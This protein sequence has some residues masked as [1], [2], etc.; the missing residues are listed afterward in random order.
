MKSGFVP[1]LVIAGVLIVGAVLTPRLLR[2]QEDRNALAAQ[3]LAE[4]A[5]R[6]LAGY[7]P[8]L[9][10]LALRADLASLKDADFDK[11]TEP[12]ANYLVDLAK[13]ARNAAQ[14]AD[15]AAHKA[16]LPGKG[17]VLPNGLRGAV[18][19]VDKLVRENDA[20]LKQASTDAQTALSSGRSVLGVAQVA[21]MTRLVEAH[22]RWA[23]ALRLRSELETLQ[24][25]A[26][27]LAG[28]WSLNRAEVDHYHGLDPSKIKADLTADLKE[29]QQMAA[30]AV[31]EVEDLKKQVSERSAALDQTRADLKKARAEQLA[32]EEAGFTLGDDQSLATYRQKYE[33]AA[34]AVGKLQ[35]HE[36]LLAGGGNEGGRFVDDNLLDGALEGGTTTEGL[37]QLEGR[38]AEAQVR[39]ERLS[40]G[41]KTI[42]QRISELDM[43]G[44]ESQESEQRYAAAG[45]Y[46]QTEFKAV[47]QSME[48]VA[49][50]AFELEDQ[51][52][53]AA[54]AA[55]DAFRSAKSAADAWTNQ[56]RQLAGELDPTGKNERLKRVAS[57]KITAA[58]S[59][60]A[61]AEA[62][63]TPPTTV[64]RP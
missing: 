10:A 60:A 54:R 5:R 61:E 18:A 23:E 11:L 22:T 64:S 34:Q 51:A 29:V 13:D 63:P 42:E 12:A 56:A 50:Q 53:A 3:R 41:A 38:L 6:E 36:Q 2:S 44:H 40:N 55:A 30:A 9:S 35:E 43:M 26:L 8:A 25:S 49:K 17:V 21:G 14:Q 57:D 15:A 62:K 46:I 59:D 1:G 19:E 4:Q 31:G 58:F 47:Q 20:L 24:R 48:T 39:S 16:H 45:E 27:G 28:K 7:I 32:L 37:E 52:L 33:A